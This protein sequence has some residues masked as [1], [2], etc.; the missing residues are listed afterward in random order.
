[1]ADE[2]KSAIASQLLN[3][4]PSSQPN[5]SFYTLIVNGDNQGFDSE[6]RYI[7]LDLVSSVSISA[8]SDITTYPL[9][10]G[11]IISDHKYDNPRSVEISGTF[12]LNGKYAS[13]DNSTFSFSGDK[14]SRLKNIEEYF[15]ALRKY[16]KFISLTSI[17]DGGTRFTTIDNLVISNL[18]FDRT[19][20]T[21]KMSLSLK[22]IYTYENDNELDILENSTD[23]NLPCLASFKSCDFAKDVLTYDSIDEMTITQLADNGLIADSF[24]EGFYDFVKLG[25]T[26]IISISAAV[27]IF[28]IVVKVLVKVG[29]IAAT[30]GTMLTTGAATVTALGAIPVVGWVAIGVGALVALVGFGVSIWKQI[31]RLS[32]ISEFKG[33]DNSK[34]NQQE[35]ERFIGVLENVRKSFN[36]IAKN[37]NIKFYNFSSNSSKQTTYLTIDDNIYQFNA[38]QISNGW[39]LKVINTSDNDSVVQTKNTSRLVGFSSLFSLKNTDAIFHT[40]SKTYVYILNKAYVYETYS[41]EDLTT[42]LVDCWK[43]GSLGYLGYTTEEMKN[44]DNITDEMKQD[45]LKRFKNEGIYKD[46][47]QF[48]FVV[49]NV[50]LTELEDALKDSI[51][52]CFKK[53]AYE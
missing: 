3:T 1:M 24:A 11:D 30:T 35:S 37:N 49:T 9:I 18:R 23:P 10:T 6:T 29:I 33:Y 13:Q 45:M 19:F 46:L 47:T 2:T 8:S 42:M 15:F 7:P 43:S 5:D 4:L 41:D 21:L 17:L 51:Y 22:E 25:G 32:L 20:S 16:G 31:K 26:T 44:R 39:S 48:V 40:D 36:T 38:E 14:G 50:K 52:N 12:A 53:E 34:Q 28:Y 27:L